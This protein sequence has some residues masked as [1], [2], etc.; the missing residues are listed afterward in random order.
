MCV[1]YL[2]VFKS[3]RWANQ[4]E[5]QVVQF[6]IKPCCCSCL[7]SL[8]SIKICPPFCWLIIFCSNQIPNRYRDYISDC[9]L[10]LLISRILA[11]LHN[12][13][14]TSRPARNYVNL[15]TT[16]A[17]RKTVYFGG[18]CICVCVRWPSSSSTQQWKTT[19][20]RLPNL[21]VLLEMTHGW[22]SLAFS[23]IKEFDIQIETNQ[24][25][26]MS[27]QSGGVQ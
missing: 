27:M 5:N 21:P 3:G 10:S 13:A 6:G 1:C 25:C 17:R 14:I 8:L 4:V 26:C 24:N 18:I 16:S 7:S 20:N 2:F 9:S 11:N 23:F 12:Y 15:S 22:C 19:M